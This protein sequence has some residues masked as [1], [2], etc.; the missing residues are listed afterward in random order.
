MKNDKDIVLDSLL[1]NDNISKLSALLDICSEKQNK[2]QNEIS[3]FEDDNRLERKINMLS[4]V[5]PYLDLNGQALAKKLIKL[6][7][8]AKIISTSIDTL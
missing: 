6:L 3:T 7:K 4:A 8:I 5:L 1:T 2:K